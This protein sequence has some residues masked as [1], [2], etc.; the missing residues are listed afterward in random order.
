[1]KKFTIPA[2]AAISVLALTLPTAGFA[3]ATY[4]LFGDAEIVSPGNSSAN[5]AQIRSDA[6]IAPNYGG[7][8]FVL[9]AGLTVAGLN[10]LST[11]YKVLTGCFGGGS[12]RFQVNVTTPSGPKNIFVYLGTPPSYGDCSPTVWLNTGNLA[13]PANL[14]DATQLGGAFYQPYASVQTA[15][16][17]YPVTGI[18]IVVDA[19]WL[20]PVQTVLVDNV[21]INGATETFETPQNQDQCKNGG[22]VTHTR[23]DGSTFK[24][25]GDCIQYVKTGK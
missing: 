23:A 4:D 11:D 22:W 16:G 6:T 7:V 13:S 2:F 20:G 19:S 17:T 5:A 25:Q 14:V 15:Y 10:T 1:M 12:P 24:N 3:A 21:V 9:P 8:D 18:Q